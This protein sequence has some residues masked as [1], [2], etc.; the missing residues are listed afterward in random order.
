LTE[1]KE[2]NY[3]TIIINEPEKLHFSRALLQ[4]D[5]RNLTANDDNVQ[6]LTSSVAA[7]VDLEGEFFY[8]EEKAK[9]LGKSIILSNSSS[10]IESADLTV[11]RFAQRFSNRPKSF[12]FD[13]EETNLIFD[14]SEVVTIITADNQDFDGSPKQ[15]VIAQ[16]IN[17]S[18]KKGIGRAFRCEAISYIPFAG[19]VAGG[20][21]FITQ[22]NDNNL[23]TITG[24][25]TA[26]DTYNFIFDGSTYGQDVVLQA[27]SIGS[28]ADLS[29]INIVCINGAILTCRGGNGGVG[30]GL[31]AG[32]VDGGDGGIVINNNEGKN[33]TINIYLNGNTGDLGNG[34]YSSDGELRASGGGGGGGDRDTELAGGG[35]GGGGRGSVSS[36]GGPGGTANPSTGTGENGEPGTALAAGDGGPGGIAFN[37]ETEEDF[38]GTDGGDGGIFGVSGANASPGGLGGLAGKGLEFSAG[39][40]NIITNSDTGR[41][42]N[43]TGDTPTSLT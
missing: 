12:V 32:G 4:Y 41:F 29:T 3:D 13:V 24:G 5:K 43:G 6:F 11:I 8:N 25:N 16:V 26:V 15:G 2:I 27:I 9:R 7:N 22:A 23:F 35:G 40:I 21:F 31:Q 37:P 17:I 38:I 19:G 36:S 20:D 42:T 1:G 10:N 14:L 33:V 34:S 18:P 30:G 28:I 39:T